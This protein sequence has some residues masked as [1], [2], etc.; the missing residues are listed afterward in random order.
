MTLT[1]HAGLAQG[2]DEWLEARRGMLTASTIGQLIT[3]KTVKPA[4]NDHSRALIATLAAERITGDVDHVFVNADMQRGVDEEP[5]ARDW[6]TANH[7]P[8][9]E[10]GFVVEDKWGYKIGVSPDGYVA[11]DGLI[12]VKA[13]R[14]KKHLKTV[15]EG[16]VPL[17][18][19]AQCQTALVVTGREWLDFISWCGGMAPFVKR[20]YPD[21]RWVEAILDATKQAEAAIEQ[22][23]DQYAT[24]T[25]GQEPT[26]RYI[27][28]E[29]TF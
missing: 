29:M 16:V 5:R 1:E 2:S 18:H 7:A 19:M 27:E 11:A 17:E 25:H 4:A 21:Q 3:P 28:V 8:V 24:A 6:Y 22:L 14:A 9:T 26:E 12:E 10:V 20:V 23:V 15:V 13:P